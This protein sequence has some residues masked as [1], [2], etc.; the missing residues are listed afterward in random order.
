MTECYAMEI[1]S[2]Q[3]VVGAVGTAAGGGGASSFFSWLGGRAKNKAYTMGAVDHA[4][5]TA[6]QSVTGQLERTEKRLEVVE[7]QHKACERNLREVRLE[8]DE[9]RSTID[10]LMAGRVAGYDEEVPQ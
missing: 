9:R 10:R 4:V 3:L 5:Q 1:S 2:L 8:L 7:D 6:M